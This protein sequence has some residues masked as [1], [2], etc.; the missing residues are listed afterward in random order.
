MI[1][2][3]H[4]VEHVCEEEI[5]IREREIKRQL[6]QVQVMVLKEMV[7]AGATGA[8]ALLSLEVTND[9]LKRITLAK[10][11]R[12]AVL[13]LIVLLP[14][15]AVTLT[16]CGSS[17]GYIGAA[18]TEKGVFEEVVKETLEE[19]ILTPEE[20]LENFESED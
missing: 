6:Q 12:D 13:W 7:K 16:L 2:A 18:L 15:A 4:E 11:M 1:P 9:I 17:A 14:V 3:H 8:G 10:E 5:R 19:R 20:M